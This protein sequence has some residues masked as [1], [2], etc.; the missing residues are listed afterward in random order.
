MKNL[1]GKIAEFAKKHNLKLESTIEN[2]NGYGKPDLIFVDGNYA[3]V[4]V[5]K[6]DR[7]PNIK[8]GDEFSFFGKTY[9]FIYGVSKNSDYNIAGYRF[10]RYNDGQVVHK[11]ETNFSNYKQYLKSKKENFKPKK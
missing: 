8:K 7:F 5:Y 9:T 10:L 2:N 1:E 3:H 11:Q 4:G 6:Q